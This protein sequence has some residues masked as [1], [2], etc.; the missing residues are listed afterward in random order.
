MASLTA[1]DLSKFAQDEGVTVES[2][3]RKPECRDLIQRLIFNDQFR[4]LQF[5]QLSSDLIRAELELTSAVGEEVEL[6]ARLS[7]L[8]IEDKYYT[9]E[10]E[11]VHKRE[12]AA[13]RTM[14]ELEK[15]RNTF[16]E[17]KAGLEVQV[18]QWNAALAKAQQ[19]QAK[20][21]WKKPGEADDE[22]DALSNRSLGSG[23]FTLA[24]RS[25]SQSHSR[26]EDD[27]SVGAVA[28]G[29]R[30]ARPYDPLASDPVLDYSEKLLH[31]LSRMERVRG[32]ARGDGQQQDDSS[33]Y[34]A[35]SLPTAV[36][37]PIKAPPHYSPFRTGTSSASLSLEI[38]RNGSP[39]GRRG[40]RADKSAAGG[41]GG[42]PDDVSVGSVISALTSSTAGGYI[43]SSASAAS[44][45]ASASVSASAA[46]P[47]FSSASLSSLRSSGTRGSLSLIGKLRVKPQPPQRDPFALARADLDPRFTTAPHLMY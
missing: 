3:C 39:R 36:L 29:S 26:G 27:E 30:R 42:P 1:E 38:G 2:L 40:R 33:P 5:A 37:S 21:I 35:M 28:G 16:A 25:H 18:K 32:M 11:T 19:A 34:A 9:N 47:A 8:E 10:Y 46:G 15:E 17:K 6:L 22:D 13:K 45:N 4:K 31:R 44:A 41:W 14:A 12:E 23:G 7:L 43:F 24:P 20:A